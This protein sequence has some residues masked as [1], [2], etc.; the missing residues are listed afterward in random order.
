MSRH[1]FIIHKIFINLN[2]LLY[3]SQNNKSVH[4]CTLFM[5]TER[6][7]CFDAVNVS[8]LAMNIT[9][10]FPTATKHRTYFYYIQYDFLLI[11]QITK[12]SLNFYMF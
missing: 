1:I 2:F 8:S 5:L 7:V 9:T 11:N 12:T 3:I 10:S 4:I 6:K